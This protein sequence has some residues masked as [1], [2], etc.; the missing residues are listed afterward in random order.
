MSNFFKR[1]R[2]STAPDVVYPSSL[3]VLCQGHALWYPEPHVTGEAQIGDVG[4]VREG[5]F[6]RIFNLN[7]SR[8]EHKVTFWGSTFEPT[9]PPPPGV[10][11]RLDTRRSLPPDHYHSSGVERVEMSGSVEV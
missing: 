11:D 4:F 10:F 2:P 1:Q 9:T 7:S 3:S 8:P 5:A 6:I